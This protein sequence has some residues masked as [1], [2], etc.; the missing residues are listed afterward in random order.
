[1]QLTNIVCIKYVLGSAGS[2]L[3]SF[4]GSS[5]PESPSSSSPPVI[6]IVSCN[7]SEN[8]LTH[9]TQY[10]IG[11]KNAL[12]E[13]SNY[14]V[15]TIL[16]Y[17]PNR[18][19]QSGSYAG[20]ANDDDIMDIGNRIRRPL[21]NI[22]KIWMPSRLNVPSVRPEPVKN[23]GQNNF[24]LE[25]MN[26]GNTLDVEARVKFYLFTRLEDGFGSLIYYSCS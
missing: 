9:N 14:F 15:P 21:S 11:N 18:F 23:F 6:S 20:G 8:P 4:M 2:I 10:Q 7:N 13:S 5:I 24:G 17:S 25:E 1:M 16:N 12:P 3:S 22:P 19:P 26:A